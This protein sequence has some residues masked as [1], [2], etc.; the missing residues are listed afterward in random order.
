MLHKLLE[1]IETDTN[2]I[3]YMYNAAPDHVYKNRLSEWINELYP[4]I[5]HELHRKFGM[6]QMRQGY[7]MFRLPG[8]V[9]KDEPMI[10]D[11]VEEEPIYY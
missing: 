11:E 7:G 1:D 3:G 2:R 4:E 5:W 9:L 8:A 6:Q 10:D